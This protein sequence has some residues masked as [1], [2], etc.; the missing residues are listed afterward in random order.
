MAKAELQE[1][2]GK[3][4]HMSSECRWRVAGIDEDDEDCRKCGQTESEVDGE[5]GSMWIVRNV[6]DLEEVEGWAHEDQRDELSEFVKSFIISSVNFKKK[7]EIS[8]TGSV[9]LVKSSET[10]RVQQADEFSHEQRSQ[11]RKRTSAT[12]TNGRR[13]KFDALIYIQYELERTEVNAVEECRKS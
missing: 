2:P 4:G 1:S 3:I 6:E 10:D 11:N 9:K 12:T 13:N 8:E 5:V 7:M